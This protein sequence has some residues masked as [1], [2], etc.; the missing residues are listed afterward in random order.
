MQRLI[1]KINCERKY[2]QG[3]VKYCTMYQIVLHSTIFQFDMDSYKNVM[4]INVFLRGK[5]ERGISMEFMNMSLVE[6]S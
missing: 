6:Q 3:D 4:S 1:C 5:K 2:N